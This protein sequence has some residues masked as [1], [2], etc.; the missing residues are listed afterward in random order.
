MH[1]LKAQ[2][3]PA[4]LVSASEQEIVDSLISRLAL[5][6]FFVQLYGRESTARTKPCPS[7]YFQA[8]RDHR[9]SSLNTLIFEDSLTG[10]EAALHSGAQ[11]L[12]VITHLDDASKRRYSDIQSTDHFDWL[13][14]A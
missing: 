10:V 13:I 8:M 2:S 14:S 1:Y 12:R 3:I 6:P 5:R 4:S 7:P 9:V 11:V